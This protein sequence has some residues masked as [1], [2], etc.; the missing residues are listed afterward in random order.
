MGKATVFL[1]LDLVIDPWIYASQLFSA[2]G[3]IS[4]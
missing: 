3:T 4:V 1:E 2:P